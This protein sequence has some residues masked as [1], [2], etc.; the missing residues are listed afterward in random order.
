MRST[1]NDQVVPAQNTSSSST[2][3]TDVI[4][5]TGHC[6]VESTDRTG[7]EMTKCARLP[8]GEYLLHG[9]DLDS[10]HQRDI[11]SSTSSSLMSAD[12]HA[13][14]S[15]N[16]PT[17]QVTDKQLTRATSS[18]GSQ[19]KTECAPVEVYLTTSRHS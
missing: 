14:G 16:M 11:S 17:A 8:I 3:L 6:E 1:S 10:E 2:S 12:Q 9:W 4:R 18:K 13:A 15:T 19:V 5:D 7:G